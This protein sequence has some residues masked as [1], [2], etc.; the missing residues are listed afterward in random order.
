MPVSTQDLLIQNGRLVTM[1][2]EIGDLARADIR[3]RGGMIAEIGVDLQPAR[4]E[5]L[6]DARGKV[7][8][9]G[10]VDTHRHV[11]QGAIGGTGGALSLG[12][13]FGVVIAGLAPLYEPDDVYA[14]VLWGAL[15]ALNSGVTTIADWSHIVT[16]PEHADANVQALH[17][18]G[19]RGMFLYGP[20][21][22]AG[23]VEWFV[24]STLLHPEDARRVRNEHF[25][26]GRN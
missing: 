9:P 17:D 7:V 8:L 20:P 3:V 4:E 5:R 18:S 13:Y 11:W 2:P 15:Q 1:D 24:E 16:T 12:G 21:V 23:L 14:G 19:I 25:A 6:V 10:L 26:S 22:A